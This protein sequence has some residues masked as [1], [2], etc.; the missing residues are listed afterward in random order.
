MRRRAITSSVTSGVHLALKNDT[1]LFAS[2]LW[3]CWWMVARSG[4]NGHIWSLNLGSSVRNV[5][6][7]HHLTVDLFLS[8]VPVGMYAS[9]SPEHPHTTV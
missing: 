9:H 7:M 3:G 6:E 4:K 8:P 2:A 5:S 1:C